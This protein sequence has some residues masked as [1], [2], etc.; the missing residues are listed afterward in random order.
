ML[1]FVGSLLFALVVG[2]PVEPPQQVPPGATSA[3]APPAAAAYKGT[4]RELCSEAMAGR[5]AGTAGG[6][7][8][9]EFLRAEYA[10]LGLAPAVGAAFVQPFAAPDPLPPAEGEGLR[11]SVRTADGAPIELDAGREFVPLPFS[12]DGPFVGDAV[13]VGHG[14]CVPELGIDDY[15][16]LELQGRVAVMLRGGPRWREVAAP[17]RAF[18]PAMSFRQKIAAAVARGAVAVLLVDRDDGPGLALTADAVRRASGAASVPCA[19]LERAVAGRLFGASWLEAAQRALDGDRPAA[20]LAQRSVIKGQIAL[21]RQQARATANV[22][23]RVDASA[24]EAMATWVVVGAHHDHIGR[25]EFASLAP[26]ADI[27]R[28]HPGADDNASG[29][30]ALLELARRFAARPPARRPVVFAAF[31]GE[32]LAQAGSRWFVDAVPAGVRVAAMLDLNMIGRARSHGLTV[33]G[34]GSGRGFDALLSAAATAVPELAIRLRDR[35]SY[36]SDQGS[37]LARRVPALL[38][39]TGLHDQ[40]H[41]PGD[42]PDLVE[43]GAALLVVD[44]VEHVVRALADGP[45]PAFV[46]GGR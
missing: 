23:G 34:S 27:G 42:V 10:R 20:P 17:V 40:Y 39:T 9:V 33:F 3:P 44:F 15:R 2:G 13:F 41:T 46:D 45:E 7:R 6:E 43:V 22:L 29:T 31:G 21:V 11:C 35:S 14:L 8:T 36:R 24:A 26:P 38:L 32:E 25:G 28:V 19:W 5:A 12:P 37:F 18:A 4:L 30:A 16:G 1:E